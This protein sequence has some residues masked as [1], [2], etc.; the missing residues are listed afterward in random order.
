M[1]KRQYYINRLAEDFRLCRENG[2]DPAAEIRIGRRKFISNCISQLMY[3]KPYVHAGFSIEPMIERLKSQG[4][5]DEK[6][7]I[8]PR[9][10]YEIDLGETKITIKMRF[11][12]RYGQ[13]SKMVLQEQFDEIDISD[14]NPD[15]IA[16]IIV[17]IGSSYADWNSEWDSIADEAM[18]LSKKQDVERISLETLIASKLKGSGIEYMLEHKKTKSTLTVKVGNRKLSMDISHRR[19]VETCVNLLPTI[20]DAME[21]LNAITDEISIEPASTKDIWT[22]S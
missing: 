12:S 4:I 17:A 13:I 9:R 3:D 1:L 8:K 2:T 20:R 15:D 7:T 18:R 14:K 5:A 16:D 22:K 10:E 11:D 19:L 6:I 21:K